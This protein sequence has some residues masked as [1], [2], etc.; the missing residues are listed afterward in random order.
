MSIIFELILRRQ[1]GKLGFGMK[2]ISPFDTSAL[3]L[4]DNLPKS[5]K[6]TAFQLLLRGRGREMSGVGKNAAR[7]MTRDLLKK[8]KSYHFVAKK[9]AK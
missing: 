7:I 5:E 8:K 2:Y 1:K 3:V 6:R 9:K 4:L